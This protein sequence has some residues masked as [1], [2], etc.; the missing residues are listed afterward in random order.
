MPFGKG[1]VADMFELDKTTLADP[2]SCPNIGDTSW[3]IQVAQSLVL[4]SCRNTEV[5]NIQ[6]GWFTAFGRILLHV[7]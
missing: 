7:D 1:S 6:I 4:S 2:K 3:A 5:D